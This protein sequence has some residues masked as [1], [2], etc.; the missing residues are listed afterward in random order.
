MT[1]NAEKRMR[2]VTIQLGL[3]KITCNNVPEGFSDEQVKKIAIQ[4]LV[5]KQMEKRNSGS[6]F[7]TGFGA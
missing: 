7:K 2:T 6:I 1:G 5:L 4:Y 3:L